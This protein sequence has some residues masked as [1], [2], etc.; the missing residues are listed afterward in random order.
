MDEKSFSIGIDVGGTYIK[1]A[2]VDSKGGMGNFLSTPTGKEQGTDYIL[3]VL[4]EL[5]LYYKNQAPGKILGVGLALP[6]SVKDKEGECLYCPNLGWNR[7]LISPGLQ[8]R[9]GLA[10]R[11]I[12]DAN[13]ACLGEYLYGKEGKMANLLC[14]TLGTGV[15][16]GLMMDHRLFIGGGS[17]VEAGHMIIDSRGTKCGCGG[18]GCW[19]TYVSA[20]AMLRRVREEIAQ[21]KSSSL[22]LLLVDHGDQ[23]TPKDI[24]QAYKLGDSLARDIVLETRHYLIIGLVNLVNLFN[25][26]AIV[27]GGGLSQA[28]DDLLAGLEDEVKGY[29]YPTLRNNLL[30]RKASLGNMA[31]L[32]GA[33][34]LWQHEVQYI[35]F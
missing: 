32:L 35:E 3:K 7:F 6:G 17:G 24:F 29:V 26:Q 16:S 19:E 20:P 1:S 34:S 11:L 4:E 18:K 31:G 5:I 21:G 12:N 27:M 9:T 28:G 22:K 33:A 15:G 30:I 25:L 14:L 10:V 23:L 8:E 13:G 2:L